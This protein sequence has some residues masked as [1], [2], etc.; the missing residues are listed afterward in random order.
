MPPH[1]RLQP[2]A[3]A[4]S[5]GSRPAAEPRALDGRRTG[6]ERMTLRRWLSASSALGIAAA[7]ALVLCALALQDIAH[8]EVDVRNEWW[9]VRIGLFL[10]GLFIVVTLST[11]VKVRRAV[12]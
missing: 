3:S 1:R 6:K 10:M 4:L 9:A 7:L 11:V 2:E 12:G 5:S 8:G